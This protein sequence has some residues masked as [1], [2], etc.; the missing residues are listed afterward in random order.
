ML[1]YG[2]PYLGACHY[3]PSVRQSRCY[4]ILGT[5]TGLQGI[6]YECVQK[7][8]PKAYTGMLFEHLMRKRFSFLFFETV[9]SI[10]F[11]LCQLGSVGEVYNNE[12]KFIG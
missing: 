2:C 7:R 12:F 1:R 4:G 5:L 10:H 11:N 8:C 3:R 9:F 6:D